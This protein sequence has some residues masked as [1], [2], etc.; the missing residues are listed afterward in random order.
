MQLGM[1]T[2]LLVSHTCMINFSYKS[3]PSTPVPW[4]NIDT[5]NQNSDSLFLLVHIPE[6]DSIEEKTESVKLPL[7]I[8]L[9]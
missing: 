1:D 4:I 7:F 5:F 9:G 8:E 3:F 6:H 2:T